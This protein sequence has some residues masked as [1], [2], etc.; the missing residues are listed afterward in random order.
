MQM[1]IQKICILIGPKSTVLIGQKGAVLI[2]QWRCSCRNEEG[3]FWSYWLK[4]DPR[5]FFI[6][7]GSDHRAQCRQAVQCR[8]EAGQ[9]GFSPEVWFAEEAPE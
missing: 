6:R 7:T 8:K 9:G 1:K 2:G 5:N 4:E 3:K